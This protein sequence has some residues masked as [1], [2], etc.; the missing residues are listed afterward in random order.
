[1]GQHVRTRPPRRIRPGTASDRRAGSRISCAVLATGPEEWAGVDLDSGAFVRARPPTGG[2]AAVP[3]EWSPFDVAV[4]E[5]GSDT[6]PPDPARPEAV[7]PAVSP[8]RVGRMRRGAARRLLK[9][10]VAPEQRWLPILGTRGPSIAY[11]DLDLSTPSLVLVATSRRTLQCYVREDGD[12]V[13]SFAWGGTTQVLPLFDARA[14][15]AV[16][17]SSPKPLDATGLASAIGGKPGYLLVG[18]ASVRG[19]HAPKVVLSVL[20]KRPTPR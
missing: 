6:E 13:C 8:E 4:V 14:R 19:G 17:A 2:G 5:L 12:V 10:L 3:G 7:A 1:M 11:V 9:R 20:A 18:L 15:A 16:V